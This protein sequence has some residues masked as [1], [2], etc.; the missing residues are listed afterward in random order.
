MKPTVRFYLGGEGWSFNI[1]TLS[2]GDNC[3]IYPIDHPS[4]FVSNENF[5]MTSPIISIDEENNS[6][7]TENTIYVGEYS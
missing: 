7:E 3:I 4:S 1:K 6:F 2:I 5:A